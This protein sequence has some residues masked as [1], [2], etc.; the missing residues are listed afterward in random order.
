ML[1]EA[2]NLAR[3]LHFPHF[4]KE[5]REQITNQGRWVGET[6]TIGARGR[7]QLGRFSFYCEATS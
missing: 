5:G 4:G 3:I 1:G 2:L 7:L 6:L